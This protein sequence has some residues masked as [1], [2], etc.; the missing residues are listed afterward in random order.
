MPMKNDYYY[1]KRTQKHIKINRISSLY[2]SFFNLCSCFY[3]PGYTELPSTAKSLLTF[4]Q[5]M[6]SCKKKEH[7]VYAASKCSTIIMRAKGSDVIQC[8]KYSVS[9]PSSLILSMLTPSPPPATLP[10]GS[11]LSTQSKTCQS[12][13]MWRESCVS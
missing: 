12:V 3:L 6:S 4:T 2:S 5:G 13:G 10:S 8:I 1:E 7:K 11:T 9:N